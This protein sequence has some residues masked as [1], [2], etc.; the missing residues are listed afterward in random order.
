MGREAATKALL[1]AGITYDKV[2]QVRKNLF[3]SHTPS[4]FVLTR[5]AYLFIHPSRPTFLP[6]FFDQRLIQSTCMIFFL[7]NP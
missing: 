4:L 1:D 6:L 7:S 3:L 2:Q 5:L